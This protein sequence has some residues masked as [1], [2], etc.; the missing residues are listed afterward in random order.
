MSSAA[1]IMAATFA[2]PTDRYAHGILGDAIE[3]GSLVLTLSDGKRVRIVLPKTRVFED[4]Q[5][6]LFDV[7]GDG[8]REVIVVES[9]QDLGARLSVYG[10]DGLEAANEHIGRAN[11]WLSPV[12]VGAADLDGDGRVELVYVDRPHLAKTLRIYEFRPGQLKL[13]AS[14]EAV[15]NHRIGER[16]IAGGIRTCDAGPEMIVADA[17]WSEILAI[18]WDG[19][20]FDLSRLG[21]H[22][23]RSS[24]FAA[25]DCKL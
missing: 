2:D 14:F 10:S 9:H 1:D 25:M 16:D 17:A 24:F 8:E 18:R 6:R 11:R 13:E 7:D 21:P 15:T 19:R 3:H 23:G 22:Q 4:T 12:G 5:P 20:R